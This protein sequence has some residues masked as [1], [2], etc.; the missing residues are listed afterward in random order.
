MLHK[1]Q[2]IFNILNKNIEIIKIESEEN[3]QVGDVVRND[4]YHS[5]GRMWWTNPD[6]PYA[7]KYLSL[8]SLYP[9]EYFGE[10]IGHP[11][12]QA[13]SL[14]YEY[15]QATYYAIFENSFNSIL[16]LGTG[17][18]EIT[19]QF[20]KHQLDYIAVEGTTAGIDKLHKIGIDPNKIIKA[21][22]KFFNGVDRKFDLV[23]CTEVVEHLEP[24]FASKIVDNCVKHAD[25]VWFS[26]AT[27]TN[28]PHYHHMNEVPLE[29]WDNIFAH[30]GFN[31]FIKLNGCMGRADRIYMNLNGIGKIRS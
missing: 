23:M 19:T 2:I 8:D 28:P 16:E 4:G 13:S 17:G 9:S 30:F 14:L 15:M 1:K 12:E 29:A 24:W 18:G 25:I 7:Y 27:G 31:Y 11:D 3:I 6:C 26:A 22:L 21:N 20:H 5:Y 10:N